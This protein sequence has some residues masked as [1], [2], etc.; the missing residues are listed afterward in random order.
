MRRAYLSY[1]ICSHGLERGLL[2]GGHCVSLIDD[3]GIGIGRMIEMNGKEKRY[4][5]SQPE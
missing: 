5:Y 3:I 2:L 1:F 4:K